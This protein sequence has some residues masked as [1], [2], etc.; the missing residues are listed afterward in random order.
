MFGMW[1]VVTQ[2]L[3]PACHV[4]AKPYG[5]TDTA[6]QSVGIRPWLVLVAR[7]FSSSLAVQDRRL[8][9]RWPSLSLAL[10]LSPSQDYSLALC[11]W[12]HV[13]VRI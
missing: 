13:H 9:L 11:L 12:V 5:D 4:S 2:P 1:K 8:L 3:L 7:G 10:A 6:S